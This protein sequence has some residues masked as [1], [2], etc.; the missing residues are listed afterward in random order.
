[1]A[2]STAISLHDIPYSAFSGVQRHAYRH[3]ARLTDL[4]KAADCLDRY[5]LPLT[6][7]WPHT[8]M[9][10]VPDW[11]HGVA[12]DLM[13]HSEQARLDGASHCDALTHARRIVCD[14][15]KETHIAT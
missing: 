1:M 6:R 14:Q 4:L 3:A 10:H 2:A 11:I 7:W 8:S 13:L 15:Q 9:L 12:F 5:R